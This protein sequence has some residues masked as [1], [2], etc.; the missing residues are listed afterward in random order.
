MIGLMSCSKKNGPVIIFDGTWLNNDY[1]VEIEK[2]KSPFLAFN[3]VIV[4]NNPIFEL[5]FSETDKNTIKILTIHEGEE[6]IFKFDEKNKLIDI[7]EDEK[8]NK[9]AKGKIKISKS[10]TTIILRLEENSDNYKFKKINK[11][12]PYFLN[13]KL[14]AGVFA[15]DSISEK[16]IV[17]KTNGDIIGFKDFNQY[18]IMFDFND[19]LPSYDIIEFRNNEKNIIEWYSYKIE[20]DTLFLYEFNNEFP[21]I[22][23]ESVVLDIEITLLKEEDY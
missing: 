20:N 13:E 15:S 7:Y 6:Y 14:I 17:I 8:K 18:S 3:Q 22:N 4:N 23:S 10:D 1:I 19:D 16:R 11:S 9:Y 5:S 21:N 12:L 2:T